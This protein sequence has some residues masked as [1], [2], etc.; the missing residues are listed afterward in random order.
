MTQETL[1]LFYALWPDEKTRQALKTWQSSLTGRKTREENLHITLYFLGN[2]SKDKVGELVHILQSL[3][4][5]A[6]QIEIDILGY[7][8]KTQIAW[9]GMS[10]KNVA[11]L[12]L[13]KELFEKLLEKKIISDAKNRFV[14]HVTLA[15]KVKEGK[16]QMKDTIFWNV[17]RMALVQS[18]TIK[19]EKG[20]GVKYTILSDR[21]LI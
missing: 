10:Q 16:K 7:F 8:S 17:K 19:T 6:F 15:R 21:F 2:Q 9:A 3:T 1:R 11:L 4:E 18:Q 14:P 5:S 20:Q 12:T 13:Q